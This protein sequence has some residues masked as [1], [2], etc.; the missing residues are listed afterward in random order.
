M[1][2]VRTAHM[3]SSPGVGAGERQS[4]V[5][6]GDVDGW[7][8]REV[9]DAADPSTTPSGTS[10]AA[11]CATSTMGDDSIV[12]M[13]R[14][15]FDIGGDDEPGLP[16]LLETQQQRHDARIDWPSTGSP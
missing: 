16:E 1:A 15:M 14:S 11:D 7:E 5:V 2:E 8:G 13:I 6:G 9:S 3:V 10:F 4:A 12:H